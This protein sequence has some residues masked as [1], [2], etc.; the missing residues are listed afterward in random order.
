MFAAAYG[1][2]DVVI[3]LLRCGANPDSMTQEGST[4]LTFAVLSKSSSTVS[5]LAQVTKTGLEG[6][7]EAIAEEQNLTES[8]EAFIA[9]TAVDEE[10]VMA[11]LDFAAKYGH[12]DLVRL[13]SQGREL[14]QPFIEKL[15]KE[16]VRSDNKDTCTA[17]FSLLKGAPSE[18]VVQI[19]KQRGIVS[20]DRGVQAHVGR[21]LPCLVPYIFTQIIL[22]A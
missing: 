7:L 11:G 9:E 20:T 12:A 13:L 15:L 16:A 4:A 21:F 6:V 18:E 10:A 8:L 19:A 17:V 22:D 3:E 2:D 5:L 1:A 14:P